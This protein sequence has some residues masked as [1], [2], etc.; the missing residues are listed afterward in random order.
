MTVVLLAAVLE[1]AVEGAD[2]AKPAEGPGAQSSRT[3]PQRTYLDSAEQ[4]AAL[5]DAAGELDRSAHRAVGMSN[6]EPR[7]RR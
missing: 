6:V 1:G 2:L 3:A 5:L 7:S 4:V